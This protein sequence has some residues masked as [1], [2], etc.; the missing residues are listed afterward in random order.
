MKVSKLYEIRARPSRFPEFVE[1]SIPPGTVNVLQCMK[2]RDETPEEIKR[3]ADEAWNDKRWNHELR[4][5]GEE[6]FMLLNEL[7]NWA[8]NQNDEEIAALTDDTILD[9]E[10]QLKI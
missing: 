6:A 7:I 8:D 1:I 4:M 10:A 3:M 9:I 5:T 2:V